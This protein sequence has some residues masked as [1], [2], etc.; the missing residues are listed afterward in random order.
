MTD[1]A[2]LVAAAEQGHYYCVLLSLL[3]TRALSRALQFFR[4]V[5]DM[6]REVHL[7]EPFMDDIM[8]GN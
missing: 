4:N 2:K 7:N 5:F 1:K 3:F 6:M 8:E